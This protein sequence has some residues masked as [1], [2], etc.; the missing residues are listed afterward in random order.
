MGKALIFKNAD[1]SANAIVKGEYEE[2]LLES[3][4]INIVPS[5]SAYGTNAKTS[6]NNR[7]RSSQNI[8][9]E[10]GKSIT[11]YGLKGLSGNK[12]A[13]RLDYCAYSNDERIGSN[14]ITT[15]SKG[16]SSNY[17]PFNTEG[18]DSCVITND[19]GVNA[20]FGFTFAAN[21]K[22]DVISAADYSPLRYRFVD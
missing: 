19:I 20:Y 6:Q 16:V 12:N 11:I 21:N 8:Y 22:T 18:E 4:L 1:F 15:G 7:I 17:F 10:N 3:G 5:E 13:I 9:I 14:V 2:L